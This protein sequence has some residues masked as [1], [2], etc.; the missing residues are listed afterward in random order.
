MIKAKK[1]MS[2]HF[3]GGP[4]VKSPPCNAGNTDSSPGWGTMIPHA[5]E[6]LSP[7][8]LEPA[9]QNWRFYAL[10]LENL[11]TASKDLA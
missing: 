6:Q 2:W 9:H 11:C 3:P 4:V 8:A 7:H 10:Q 5:T 1:L